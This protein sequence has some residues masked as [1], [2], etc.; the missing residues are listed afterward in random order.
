MTSLRAIFPSAKC[1]AKE[2]RREERP[3]VS[4]A[5]VQGLVMKSVS[6][7]QNSVNSDSG[8]NAPKEFGGNWKISLLLFA[9]LFSHESI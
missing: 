6:H 5:S 8:S 1:A 9:L 4:W 7:K 3:G 2:N